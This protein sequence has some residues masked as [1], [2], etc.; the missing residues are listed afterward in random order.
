MKH[1]LEQ[2]LAFAQRYGVSGGEQNNSPYVWYISG[3]YRHYN[4]DGSWDL[5]A[6]AAERR[7]ELAWAKLIGEC[8]HAWIAP[9]ANSCPVEEAGLEMSGDAYVALDRAIIRQLRIGQTGL[10]MRPGWNARLDEWN[11]SSEGAAAEHA[12]AEQQ[13]LIILTPSGFKDAQRQLLRLAPT[14]EGDE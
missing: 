2:A 14:W 6:M 9:L 1:A 12:T 7:D 11:P 13:G 4:P 3:R 10:V 8:G 5:D